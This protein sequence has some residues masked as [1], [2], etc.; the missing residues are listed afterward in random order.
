[1]TQKQMRPSSAFFRKPAAACTSAQTV[2]PHDSHFF[3]IDRVAIVTAALLCVAAA[4]RVDAQAELRP[5]LT[6]SVTLPADLDRVL[7]DYERA[8]LAKDAQGLAA[9]FTPDGMALPNG[10]PPARG[11]AAIAEAYASS[12]GSPLALRALAYAVAGDLAYIVGGFAPA[13]GEPDFGK[14]VLVL[15]RAADGRWLIAADIDN[16]NAMPRRAPP[17]Q[18]DPTKPAPQS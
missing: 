14:F 6:P 9:L 16:A 15:R 11:A 4:P 17:Q 12:A 1:M 2:R 7:R 13:T 3:R 5:E 8:W 10:R 18:H